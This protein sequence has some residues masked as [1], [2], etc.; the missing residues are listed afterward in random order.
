MLGNR[1]IKANDIVTGAPAPEISSLT[2]NASKSYTGNNVVCGPYHHGYFYLADG[3]TKLYMAYTNYDSHNDTQYTLSTPYDFSTISGQ[4]QSVGRNY[5]NNYNTSMFWKP[6]GTKYFMTGYTNGYGGGTN[7]IIMATMSTPWN[8]STATIHQSDRPGGFAGHHA[9]SITFLEDGATWYSESN[10]SAS[11]T[12]TDLNTVVRQY[13]LSNPWDYS[14]TNSIVNT[15]DLKTV[16]PEYAPGSYYVS[17]NGWADGHFTVHAGGSSAYVL[18]TR[19]V[20]GTYV[21]MKV[22]KMNMSTPGD[23]TTLSVDSYVNIP[24]QQFVDAGC[25]YPP[26]NIQVLDDG[27][28]V[29]T[30]RYGNSPWKFGFFV[31]D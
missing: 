12:A 20:S 9:N 18:L 6:D 13:S 5:A 25:P 26:G 30:N 8:L 21:E 22:C 14:S 11:N 19:Y 28:L 16:I 2:Y 23:I 7:T 1:L 15:V 10:I 29:I 27:S 31:F 4:I 24:K 17:G 3:G